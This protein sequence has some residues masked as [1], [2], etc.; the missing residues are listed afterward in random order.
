MQVRPLFSSRY[1]PAVH[2]R[3]RQ[4]LKLLHACVEW[5]MDPPNGVMSSWEQLIIRLNLCSWATAATPGDALCA[6]GS[7]VSEIDDF[8]LIKL[9][10]WQTIYISSHW[11]DFFF[12]CLQLWA[13]LKMR[14]GTRCVA[15]LLVL[16][17]RPVYLEPS[18]CHWST[19]GIYKSDSALLKVSPR[20]NMRAAA[21]TWSPDCRNRRCRVGNLGEEDASCNN[22]VYET[23][24][25]FSST[26]VPGCT[27]VDKVFLV[28]SWWP[29]QL[30]NGFT[31]VL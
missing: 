5:W 10:S 15:F 27:Q 26:P 31:G 30:R 6:A 29:K 16:Q 1:F 14:R 7:F 9:T 28:I 11:Y 23:R 13:L 19:W 24:F 2:K 21:P 17:T 12:F 22:D 18:H 3:R 8:C 25:L 20:K 4:A